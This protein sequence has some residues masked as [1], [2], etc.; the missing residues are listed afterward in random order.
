MLA[1]VEN[2]NNA[3]KTGFVVHNG[4]I[5]ILSSCGLIFSYYY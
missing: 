4:T 1:Y 3:R 2:N 5:I